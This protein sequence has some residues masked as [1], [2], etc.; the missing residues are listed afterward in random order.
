MAGR[1]AASYDFEG[2]FDPERD[3]VT[4]YELTTVSGALLAGTVAATELY[5]ASGP[6]AVWERVCELTRYAEDRFQR[7]DGVTVTSPRSEGARS[8]LFLFAV[9]N[10]EPRL[11]AGLPAAGGEGGVPRGGAVRLRAAVAALF[12]HRGRDR[13][14][15]R[16]GGA[17][18]ARRDPRRRG[19]AAR[20][21]RVTRGG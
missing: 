21:A 6:Q 7:I 20:T 15:R 14:R 16:D 8:G 5:L 17:C 4:K 1:A 2:N 9:A 18:G 12:Q 10:V 13:R 3:N 19:A 11:L